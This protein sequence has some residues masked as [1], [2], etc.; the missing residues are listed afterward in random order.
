MI[1][2]NTYITIAFIKHFIKG[3]Q[4]LTIKK[5]RLAMKI[6]ILSIFPKVKMFFYDFSNVQSSLKIKEKW[7]KV[8]KIPSLQPSHIPLTNMLS[9]VHFNNY[10]LLG[11]AISPL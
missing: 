5:T 11:Y 7:K 2:S 10:S 1:F 8:K 4:I 6:D 9:L 3:N